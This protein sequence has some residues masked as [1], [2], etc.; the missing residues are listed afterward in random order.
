LLIR[1]ALNPG[2]LKMRNPYRAIHEHFRLRRSLEWLTAE[3]LCERYGG[4][5]HYIKKIADYCASK[6]LTA[7]TRERLH[8]REYKPSF[9]ISFNGKVVDRSEPKA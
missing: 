3:A 6:K 9:F 4:S 5:L 7:V 8:G 2:A 1:P